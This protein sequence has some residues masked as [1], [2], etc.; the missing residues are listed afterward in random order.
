MGVHPSR[1]AFTLVELLV[2][3][4]ILAVL[5][6]LLLPAVQKLRES[7]NR[8]QCQNNLKQLGLAL[9]NYH[10]AFQTFPP[11]YRASVPYSDG[12]TDT[13]PGWGWGAFILP[14]IE[15]DSVY[16]QLHLQQPVQ[17]SPAIQ[18]RL[19]VFLCPSDMTPVMAFSVLDGFGNTVCLAAPC[20]YAACVGGDESGTTDSAGL[21]VFYRNSQTRMIDIRDGASNTILIGERA[22]SNANGVWAGAINGGVIKRGPLNPCPGTGSGWYPAATLVQ[23]HS[24]LNNA[25]ADTDGGLD[26]FSSRHPGG[27]N[28][29]FADGSIHFIR[30]VPHDLPDGGYTRESLIFQA[31][32]TRANGEAIPAD[33]LN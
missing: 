29:V 1:S 7:A 10:D 20:S 23:A 6:G 32:G 4:A 33:W 22:W 27:S 19:Q 30:D 5:I 21:G 2:V 15:Q 13:I 14:Y 11:G 18:T 16:R 9:H 8:M 17:D 3:L 28:F 25:T 12:A 31:L 26:D 24:H